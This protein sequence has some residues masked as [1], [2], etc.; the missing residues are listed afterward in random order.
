MSPWVQV[1][2]TFARKV[3]DANARVEVRSQQP[4]DSPEGFKDYEQ[5]AGGASVIALHLGINERHPKPSIECLVG[6]STSWLH[7]AYSMAWANPMFNM[8]KT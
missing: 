2:S 4:A 5:S 8:P 6:G 3:S 1:A 7:K